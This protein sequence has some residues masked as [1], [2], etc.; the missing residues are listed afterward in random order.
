MNSLMIWLNQKN[1]NLNALQWAV[2]IVLSNPI[3]TLWL[4]IQW[5]TEILDS[6]QVLQ[7]KGMMPQLG[8]S[9]SQET[10]M[11]PNVEAI[12]EDF[13]VLGQ[14]LV[15]SVE[16]RTEKWVIWEQEKGNGL[17]LTIVFVKFWYQGPVWCP[18]TDYLACDWSAN[19]RDKYS[20]WNI[21]YFAQR[22]STDCKGSSFF[23]HCH[24][25]LH[26]GWLSNTT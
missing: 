9:S 1:P 5:L 23:E 11:T 3:P 19:Y 18:A 24:T 12:L 20:N 15:R 4:L 8:T 10:K 6:L 17:I 26:H 25:K 21:T 7:A 2:V 22:S 13:Q 14:G 16:V